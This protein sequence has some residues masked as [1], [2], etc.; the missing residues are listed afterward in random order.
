MAVARAKRGY[1]T[2]ISGAESIWVQDM[3][4][5]ATQEGHG[6]RNVSR[7]RLPREVQEPGVGR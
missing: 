7:V 1:N 6:T 3:G 4:P 5:I 2:R